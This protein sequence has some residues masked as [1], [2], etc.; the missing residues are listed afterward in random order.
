MKKRIGIVGMMLAICLSAA[1]MAS[2]MAFADGA[3]YSVKT[4]SPE[5]ADFVNYWG[6]VGD[7]DVAD[8]DGITT[9]AH[10]GLTV[11]LDGSAIEINTL[12]KLLSKSAEPGG[13]DVDGWITYSFSA[14]PADISSDTTYPYHGGSKNGYFLHANN[15]S[16]NAAPNCAMI[17]LYKMENGTATSIGGA[18]FVDNIIN[19]RF[20]L[21]FKEEASGKYTLDF[22]RLSD[23]VSLK[24]IENIDLNKSLFINEN[25]QTFF[26]TA[27]Y[28]GSGCDGN[29]WEHRELCVYSAK[30]LTLDAADAVITLDNDSYEFEEGTTYKPVVTVEVGGTALVGDVDYFVEY[31]NNKAVGTGSAKISFIGD[32]AGNDAV[33]KTFEIAEKVVE[34]PD[35]DDDDDDG[36]T[37]RGCASSASTASMAIFSALAF[38]G[39]SVLGKR[40]VR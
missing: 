2:G 27:I 37:K 22:I 8:G 5:T 11:P 30:V 31:A 16:Q 33:T 25:G 6:G 23:E 12:F 3:S 14:T 35:D 20:K 13:D 18:F 4:Y 38:L 36:D 17:E 15:V 32:Y 39:T 10:A 19:V 24:K 26:S 7:I 29:H 40:R 1:L 9:F 28:E 21:S 34:I